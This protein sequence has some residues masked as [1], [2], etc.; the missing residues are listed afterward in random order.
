MAWLPTN[1]RSFQ[2]ESTSRSEH[3][4]Q[5]SYH[6]IVTFCS[7]TSS[8]L[9]LN[10][11][12]SG[13]YGLL[14]WNQQS[15][16]LLTYPPATKHRAIFRCSIPSLRRLILVDLHSL[17]GSQPSAHASCHY[18]AHANK[19]FWLHSGPLTKQFL[20]H[21]PE[22]HMTNLTGKEFHLHWQ[23]KWPMF[24]PG[25]VRPEC[26]QLRTRISI[27]AIPLLRAVALPIWRKRK[28]K[29]SLP[30]PVSPQLE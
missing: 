16:L 3:P 20:L 13:N 25:L 24:I 29:V 23:R 19:T 8:T 1:T 14:L 26:V 6:A 15:A 28:T 7:T 21:S 9:D 12:W 22:A 18:D 2:I 10:P 27:M 17:L 4:L 11:P 30:L 5:T